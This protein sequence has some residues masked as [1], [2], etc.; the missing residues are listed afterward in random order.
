[1]KSNL[2]CFFFIQLFSSHYSFTRF[3]GI[4]VHYSCGILFIWFS[5]LL[6][7]FGGSFSL[8]FE[9]VTPHK[10]IETLNLCR[11][12]D[13]CIRIN[14]STFFLSLTMT[15]S[16]PIYSFYSYRHIYTHTTDARFSI[17]SWQ[18]KHLFSWNLYGPF[19]LYSVSF[20]TIKFYFTFNL[21]LTEIHPYHTKYK[22][23]FARCPPGRPPH[24]TFARH[25]C[26]FLHDL[27]ISPRF[28]WVTEI[29]HYSM[30][31]L[32][33]ISKKFCTCLFC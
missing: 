19:R 1:M 2:C 32:L 12:T 15:P 28:V 33:V 22:I 26:L 11:Q 20:Q 7:F 13:E 16:D 27:P 17:C 5:M 6:F 18:Q 29:P 9:F 25:L 3:F 14:C 31:V 30:V 23:V 4:C 10:F 8:T 24:I 21:T